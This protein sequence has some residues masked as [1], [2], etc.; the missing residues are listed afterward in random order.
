M[1]SSIDTSLG[2][3]QYKG[4]RVDMADND[5][6]SV[7]CPDDNGFVTDLKINRNE[8]YADESWVVYSKDGK[9]LITCIKKE[10]L[11]NYK[12][13]EGTIVICDYAF[14][15]C[16]EIREVIIPDSVRAIGK[17]AFGNC[18]SLLNIKLPCQLEVIREKT[19]GGCRALSYINMP[20]SL[21][22]IEDNAFE[23]CPT[24][25]FIFMAQNVEYIAPNAFEFDEVLPINFIVPNLTKEYY[26]KL[27]SGK[28]AE[29]QTI[30][31]FNNYQKERK[32][33]EKR[34]R[35]EE[36]TETVIVTFLY[37]FFMG[38]FLYVLHLLTHC[39]SI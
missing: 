34:W 6:L 39:I 13:K 25:G 37:L 12:V 35:S 1:D 28:R 29:I 38:G 7:S 20:E 18:N 17:E 22:R 31:E 8:I 33:K 14:W 27:L 30:E 16:G 2:Q 10:E 36:R 5:L 15:L 4:N 26:A 32:D 3:F 23:F 9:A 21:K 19:F 11:V 24:L